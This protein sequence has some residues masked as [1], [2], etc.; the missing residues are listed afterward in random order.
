MK[1]KIYY[2]AL[3]IAD[4]VAITI[5]VATLL[6]YKDKYPELSNVEVL[7]CFWKMNVAFILYCISSAVIRT[8]LEERK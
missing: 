6:I 3:N 8:N 2:W 7:L 5:I 4:F 1:R